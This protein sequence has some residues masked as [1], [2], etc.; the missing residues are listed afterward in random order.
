MLQTYGGLADDGSGKAVQMTLR[1]RMLFREFLPMW[2]VH[3]ICL[4]LMYFLHRH[5]RLHGCRWWALCCLG[6][7]LSTVS[8]LILYFI[9]SEIVIISIIP[10]LLKLYPLQVL[11][12]PLE[13]IITAM[14]DPIIMMMVLR[15]SDVSN[16]GS[17]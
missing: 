8:Y 9:H 6:V 17:L 7:S 3:P 4:G 12:D 2:S 5:V 16:I 14:V 11:L 13:T 10:L 1:L 15:A